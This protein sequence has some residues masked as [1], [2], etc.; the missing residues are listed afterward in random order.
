VIPEAL[1]DGTPLVFVDDAPTPSDYKVNKT[2]YFVYFDYPLSAHSATVG[3]SNTI[4]E[5]P[6]VSLV[7]ASSL[8]VTIVFRRLIKGPKG[9]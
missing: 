3:G 5:F 8:L 1:L 2:H 9:R 4:P 7:V 6:S